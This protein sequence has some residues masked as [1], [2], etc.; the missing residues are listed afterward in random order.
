MVPNHQPEEAESVSQNLT[1]QNGKHSESQGCVEKEQLYGQDRFEGAYLTV[2]VSPSHRR[3]LQFVWKGVW[4]QFK[5][6]LI[7]QL[8]STKL[9]Q[10]VAAKQGLCSVIYL[11]DFLLMANSAEK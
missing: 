2:L 10:P 7:Y 11:D 1:F 9:V 6:L 5:A 8:L 3:F 4:Y